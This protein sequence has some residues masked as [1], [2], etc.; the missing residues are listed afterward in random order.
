MQLKHKRRFVQY[1]K[2]YRMCQKWFAKFCAGDFSLDDAPRSDRPIDVDG[3]QTETSRTVNII[4][5][6]RQLTHATYPSQSSYR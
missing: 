2:K 5:H 6:G 3:D 1:L 4:P